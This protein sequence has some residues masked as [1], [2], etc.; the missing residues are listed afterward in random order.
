V[1]ECPLT[2]DKVGMPHR[3]YL[4]KPEGKHLAPHPLDIVIDQP[5]AVAEHFD[6]AM[7]LQAA[8]TVAL[9]ESGLEVVP[10]LE[11]D[12]DPLGLPQL[13]YGEQPRSQAEVWADIAE[14]GLEPRWL[15]Q[16]QIFVTGGG[17]GF[18]G[19]LGERAGEGA[20]IRILIEP[21]EGDLV[22]LIEQVLHRVLEATG[23]P[24]CGPPNILELMN[25]ERADC[26]GLIVSTLGASVR[27]ELGE[28]GTPV[29]RE[30]ARAHRGFT[31]RD[32]ATRAARLLLNSHPE[33]GSQGV[34]ARASES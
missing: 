5:A 16:F 7:G 15:L 9:I 32:E 23:A 8:L 17:V 33:R 11:T 13:L 27:C 18:E 31:A 20:G 29:H 25:V 3:S 4:S 10:A 34:N 30:I 14:R 1:Q 28:G 19:R 12:P 22:T 2:V 26:L 6:F 24:D 21:S